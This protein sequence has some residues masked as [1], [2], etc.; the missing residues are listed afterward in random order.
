MGRSMS[1]E[2]EEQEK[3][4]FL[5][6]M[7]L[8]DPAS[9]AALGLAA[10]DLYNKSDWGDSMRHEVEISKAD[11]AVVGNVPGYGLDWFEDL[12]NEVIKSSQSGDRSFNLSHYWLHVAA[13]LET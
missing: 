6:I 1:I 9:V 7:Q 11:M 13:W 10:S 5:P 2:A 12:A 8:E 4:L 3:V